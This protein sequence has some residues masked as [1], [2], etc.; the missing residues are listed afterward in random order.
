MKIMVIKLIL[1][2]N[3]INKNETICQDESIFS[4][5]MPSVFFRAGN[6]GASPVSIR[7]ADGKQTV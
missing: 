6:P 4:R 7:Y 3:N 2:D 5:P 1:P